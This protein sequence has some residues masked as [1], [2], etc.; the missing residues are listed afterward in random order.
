MYYCIW[1]F[2]FDCLYYYYFP[3]QPNSGQCFI[4]FLVELR[5]EPTTKKI[6]LD[7]QGVTVKK[8]T[9]ANPNQRPYHSI[10]EAIFFVYFSYLNVQAYDVWAGMILTHSQQNHL[11]EDFPSQFF[12][13][14]RQKQNK[15]I[16]KEKRIIKTSNVVI[17]LSIQ[18]LFQQ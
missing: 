10:N 18:E 9:Y 5:F 15:N 2:P 13:L 12:T 7:Y 16:L 17:Y 14:R 11:P 4:L 6:R 8:L 3:F 1:P